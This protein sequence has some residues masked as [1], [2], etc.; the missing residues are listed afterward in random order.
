MKTLAR[1]L[2]LA[3]VVA[4]GLSSAV[5]QEKVSTYKFVKGE[6]AKYDVVGDLRISLKGSHKDFI[7]GGHEEPISMSYRA[8]FENVVLEVTPGDGSAQLE[9]RVRTLSAQGMVQGMPFKYEWDR[10]KDEGRSAGAN[11]GPD[12]V[13]GLFRKWCV[14]PLQFTVSG[15]GKY[16]TGTKNY[17]QMVNKAGVMYWLIGTEAKPW[18]TEEKIAAPLFHTKLVIEFKN[19][20]TKTVP[21]EGRKLMVIAATPSLKGIEEAPPEAP[22]LVDG[23]VEYTVTGEK[24]QVEFDTTNR[25]LHSVNLNLKIKLN[26][27]GTVAGGGRRD[28]KG[29]VTFTES[30]KYKD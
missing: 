6:V 23:P 15:E 16:W 10:A 18:L 13:A 24:N 28:L 9:R 4:F 22:R 5:A 8:R 25:R 30:Q 3:L 7:V 27:H 20:F 17:D 11:E 12:T 19:V 14:E 21:G 29:E 1:G 2:S 26:G